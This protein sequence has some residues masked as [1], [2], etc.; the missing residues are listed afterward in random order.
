MAVNSSHWV[1][2]P[3][4]WILTPAPA[5]GRM[6]LQEQSKLAGKPCANDACAAGIHTWVPSETEGVWGVWETTSLGL[7]RMAVV[8]SGHTEGSGSVPSSSH[9]IPPT[10]TPAR[11][12]VIGNSC[13]N[14]EEGIWLIEGEASLETVSVEDT[15]QVA[16]EKEQSL[17]RNS[18]WR[19]S[20][21]RL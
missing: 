4:L 14:S 17:E 8:S 10:P 2:V 12:L 15:G 20:G 19:G 6:N 18:L 16:Q 13:G 3:V 5:W 1:G 21:C 7:R 9:P 11:L